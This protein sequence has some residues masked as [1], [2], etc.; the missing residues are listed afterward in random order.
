MKEERTF[1]AQSRDELTDKAITQWADGM[2][3]R[4]TRIDP[5]VEE[6]RDDSDDFSNPRMVVK[7]DEQLTLPYYYRIAVVEPG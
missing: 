5:R 6:V 3:L 4:I 1:V 2:R 7:L